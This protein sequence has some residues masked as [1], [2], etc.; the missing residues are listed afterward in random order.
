MRWRLPGIFAGLALTAGC[1]ARKNEPSTDATIF[2]EEVPCVSSTVA[3]EHRTHSS[4]GPE[5]YE[6]LSTYLRH[7]AHE[8][9]LAVVPV[10]RTTPGQVYTVST[11]LL[12][13]VQTRG[14]GDTPS[15][16][17]LDV[18]HIMCGTSLLAGSN[19]TCE[20]VVLEEPEPSKV[21]AWVP[22][23]YAL[24]PEAAATHM[25]IRIARR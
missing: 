16:A 7:R 21:V 5:C 3:Q 2:V 1:V 23:T 19:K 20:Q 17:T 11:P 4:G 6:A 9:L 18:S 22:I 13:V 14:S 8:R 25:L 12:L 24:P 15:S 10:V